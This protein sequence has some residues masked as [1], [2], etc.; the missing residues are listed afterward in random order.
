ME[1]N[2]RVLHNLMIAFSLEAFASVALS[3]IFNTFHVEIF[4][5][6][7]NLSLENYA[8]GHA[9]FAFINVLNDLIGA[10]IVDL[11]A[12][13]S[14]SRAW[15][16]ATFGGIWA[17]T[18]FLPWFPWSN[19]PL[20][21]FIV[22]LSCYDTMYSFCAIAGGSLLTELEISDSER[23]QILKVKTVIGMVTGFSLTRLGQDLF[24]NKDQFRVFCMVVALTSGCAYAGFYYKIQQSKIIHHPHSLVAKS[25][26]HKESL[27]LKEIMKDFWKLKNFRYW[28]GMEMCLE[29][30]CNFNRSYLR[31]F[32]SQ[33]LT[34]ISD[35]QQKLLVSILP[36][37]KNCVKF[38]MFSVM[39]RIGVYQVYRIS[40][41]V[42]IAASLSCYALGASSSVTVLVFII[43]NYIVSE[44]PNGGFPIAMSNMN[45]ELQLVRIKSG[46]KNTASSSAMFMG[47][48]A[49]FCK[50]MDSL[51]PIIA[52]NRLGGV[53]YAKGALVGS[54]QLN[55]SR[56]FFDLLVLPPLVL[57]MFQYV[58]WSNYSLKGD[59][60]VQ[61]ENELAQL[62]DSDSDNCGFNDNEVEIGIKSG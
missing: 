26:N 3:A 58:C 31:L 19:Y 20:T 62:R 13:T 52:A 2:Q 22:S 6:E 12:Q 25:E 53:G 28:L 41:L 7:Y 38:V 56:A 50:P 9:I 14:Y 39:D 61:I 40:F 43:L 48:N 35:D 36:T 51:L 32:V 30:L 60:M 18:F 47:F 55:I 17:L 8:K 49:L 16:L 34:G 59:G 27:S 5:N 45:K 33:L 10:Y 15:L 46:R 4:L 57:C 42:K 24:E 11:L 54:E 29:T 21:H 1:G 44:L 37:L 23:I